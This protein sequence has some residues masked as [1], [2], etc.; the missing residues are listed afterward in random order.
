LLAA[1]IAWLLD[2]STQRK[3]TADPVARKTVGEASI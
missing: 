3:V 1:L 2:E